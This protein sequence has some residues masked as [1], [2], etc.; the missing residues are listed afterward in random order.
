[1]IELIRSVQRSNGTT[2]VYYIDEKKGTLTRKK[3]YKKKL[4]ESR[5]NQL[6]ELEER[7]TEMDKSIQKDCIER[8]K[9]NDILK[10]V[11]G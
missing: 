4:S 3:E 1:M 7:M 6:L 10:K 2:T 8:W 5:R 11:V 9:T